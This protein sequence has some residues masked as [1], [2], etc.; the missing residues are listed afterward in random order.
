MSEE[1]D[2]IRLETKEE[3]GFVVITVS[4]DGHGGKT[5]LP[6]QKKHKSVGTKNVKTR[7]ALLCEGELSIEKSENGTSSIIKIPA[8]NAV[9]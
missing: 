7:L 6:T 1:G 9:K 4:D 8:K 5:E 2:E 3:N